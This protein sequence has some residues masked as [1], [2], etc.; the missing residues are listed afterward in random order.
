MK[1]QT[2]TSL[3]IRIRPNSDRRQK[4]QHTLRRLARRPHEHACRRARR[5]PTQEFHATNSSNPTKSDARICLLPSPVELGSATLSHLIRRM[6]ASFWRCNRCQCP[7]HSRCRRV[8]RARG[9]YCLS[10]APCRAGKARMQAED[11]G[12]KLCGCNGS[13]CLCSLWV[14]VQCHSS[15]QVPS[16]A[17][18]RKHKIDV[19]RPICREVEKRMIFCFFERTRFFFWIFVNRGDSVTTYTGCLRQCLTSSLSPVHLVSFTWSP[20]YLKCTWEG[21][22]GTEFGLYKSKTDI[23]TNYT[24]TAKV[25]TRGTP[26]NWIFFS[27][28]KVSEIRSYD[29]IIRVLLGRSPSGHGCHYHWNVHYISYCTY[30]LGYFA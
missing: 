21:S 14:S 8:W 12:Q 13:G 15:S 17:L 3:D 22:L 29:D 11:L 19:A 30:L 16:Q 24:R 9:L 10:A 2:H 18:F 5:L 28:V 6:T 20:S 25:Q 4:A 1:T 23:R 26:K 7:P 27:Q